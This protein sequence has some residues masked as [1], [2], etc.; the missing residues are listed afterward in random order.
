M[1]T[2]YL[3]LPVLERAELRLRCLFVASSRLVLSPR[4]TAAAFAGL[5]SGVRDQKPL[6]ARSKMQ[7]AAKASSCHCCRSQGHSSLSLSFVLC[8][9]LT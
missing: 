5:S 8:L 4:S 7:R 1:R 3:T 9:V 6:Q 2:L